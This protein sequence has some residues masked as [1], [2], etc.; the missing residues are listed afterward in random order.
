MVNNNIS[1][2]EWQNIINTYYTGY[3]MNESDRIK[4]RNYR[5]LYLSNIDYLKQN[6]YLNNFK[7]IQD[8][9]KWYIQYYNINVPL[10]KNNNKL[11]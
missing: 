6:K 2:K 4:R 1:K 8:Y 11:P 3:Y 10:S 9:N 7:K 5:A